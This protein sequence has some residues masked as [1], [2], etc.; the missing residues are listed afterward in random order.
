MNTTKNRKKPW[1]RLNTRLVIVVCLAFCA[2]CRPARWKEHQQENR[3]STEFVER[4]VSTLRGLDKT[5][6][7]G[8]GFDYW[9]DCGLRNAYHHLRTFV[10]YEEVVALSPVPIFLSGP[11]GESQ[12]ALNERYDFGHYNPE[13]IE[14]IDL[15]VDE[16]M[17]RKALIES[18]RPLFDAY[19][20]STAAVYL[21]TY[22][23]LQN[24]PDERDRLLEVYQG[25]MES[26]TLPEGHYYEIAWEGDKKYSFLGP[27]YKKHNVNVV[28][29]AVYFWLRRDLDGTSARIFQVGLKVMEAFHP[30]KEWRKGLP[31]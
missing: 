23:A 13:F 31:K 6:Y 29:P 19:L 7:N 2:S 14:W 21:D 22:K 17:G 26:K 1:R 9:P 27:L 20:G 12:L 11:H 10:L 30:E 28:A 15:H 3:I 16:V 24:N 8:R 5:E 25:G 18:A 4:V